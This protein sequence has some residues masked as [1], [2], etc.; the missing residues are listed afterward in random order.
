MNK[1]KIAVL[2]D[3]CCDVPQ[4]FV[5]QY[6]MYV[7]PLKVVYKDAE[8]LDGVD[9]TPEQVYQGLEREVPKTSLPSGERITEI[10]DQI[11][12]DGFQKVIAITLSSG[13]S[14]T[15]NM[16]HL[17]ADQLEDMEVFIMDTRKHID[18]RRISCHSGSPLY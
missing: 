13:L 17:I 10:F 12:A 8:Y 15:N 14:G 2:V 5:E 11:R 4:T 3:T 7:I 6:H 9:I 18:W 16:I 1:E